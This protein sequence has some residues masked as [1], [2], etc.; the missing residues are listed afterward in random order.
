MFNKIY[1]LLDQNDVFLAAFGSSSEVLSFF[2][3]LCDITKE[4]FKF[5]MFKSDSIRVAEIYFNTL[6]YKLIK[7]KPEDFEIGKYDR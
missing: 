1:I 7:C 2:W 3:K 5:P 4:N 6:G